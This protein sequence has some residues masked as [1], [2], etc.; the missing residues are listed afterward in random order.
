L[1]KF[2]AAASNFFYAFFKELRMEFF[3]VGQILATHGLN[4]EVKVGVITDFPDQ[5]FAPGSKL[6]LADS[7]RQLTVKSGRP[8]K[9]FWLVTFEE[10][11]DIDEAQKLRGQKLVVSE[12][13]QQALPAGS[14]Y[15]HD[16]LGCSVYENGHLLGKVTDIEAPGAN[17][18][19]QV[20]EKS[21]Q[22]FWLPYI[23]SVVKNVDIAGQRIDVELMEGLRDED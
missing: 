17:D 21:G 13:D 14:Y 18:I 12:K 2:E 4:G 6:Y 3:D 16:I 20:T 10:I 5:R 23:P 22:T 8:F 15:Y 1:A 11:G 9:Q 7:K 19:W